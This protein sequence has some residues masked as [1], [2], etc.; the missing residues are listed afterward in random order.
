[1]KRKIRQELIRLSE[2]ILADGEL[3]NL[4]NLYNRSRA[5]YE[6]IAVLKFIEDN[7]NSLEVDVSKSEIG[8]R[9][10]RMASAVLD[11]NTKVPES[12]PHQEDIMTP[13]IDT[14]KHMVSEMTEEED[15]DEVLIRLL[16]KRGIAG[17]FDKNPKLQSS[18][19][20][21]APKSKSLNDTIARS[22]ISIGLND[23]LAFVSHLFGGSSEAFNQAL[24]KLNQMESQEDSMSY[25]NNQVKPEFNNW[26]GKEEYEERF[27][28]LITKRFN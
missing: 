23:R 13:G 18:A 22:K 4:S 19:T 8:A 5:L 11:E 1:M 17:S 24:T 12:N 14:I 27:T 3:K 28:A 20:A 16:S 25:L 21:A 7:L 2:E 9:F 15:L 6:K 10:E 26:Q